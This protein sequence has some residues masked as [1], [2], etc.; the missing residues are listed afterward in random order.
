MWQ[1]TSGDQNCCS[2]MVQESHKAKKNNYMDKKSNYCELADDT[3]LKYCL[4]RL[5][6]SVKIHRIE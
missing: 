6:T 5:L 1:L 3:E 2:I 4:I